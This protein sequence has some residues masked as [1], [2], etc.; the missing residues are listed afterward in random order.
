MSIY[1][2]ITS[3]Y[4]VRTDRLRSTVWPTDRRH[5]TLRRFQN[6]ETGRQSPTERKRE[7]EKERERAGNREG[8]KEI[9]Q[10]ANDGGES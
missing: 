9:N 10:I 5:H 6:Q 1:I 3:T 2:S 7:E 8:E 4:P